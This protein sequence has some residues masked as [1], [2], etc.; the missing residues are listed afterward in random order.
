MFVMVLD[1]VVLHFVVGMLVS[2]LLTQGN[3]LDLMLMLVSIFVY[4]LR[5]VVGQMLVTMA[6]L[7]VVMVQWIS[8]AQAQSRCE[9]QILK[10]YNWT[11]TAG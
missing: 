5:F 9:N 7:V 1:M 8:Q 10:L 3:A 2:M 6:L 11:A 4:R